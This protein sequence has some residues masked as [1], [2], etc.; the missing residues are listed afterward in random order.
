MLEKI[1]KARSKDKDVIR[2]VE[3]MKKMRVKELQGNEWQMKG[4]LVL[5]EEKVYI[6]KDKELRAEVIWWHYNVL[7]AGH[8]GK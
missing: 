2:V 8:R 4:E 3:E 7:A 1:K 6:P 5:K